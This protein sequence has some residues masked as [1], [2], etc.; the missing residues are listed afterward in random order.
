MLDIRKEYLDEL[1][2]IF[3]GYCP[4]A[5]IWA[6]GS[7]I[8]NNSHSGSD[9]DLAVKNLNDEKKS[10]TELRRI[11]NDSD[12]PFLIEIQE[13]AKLPKSFQDEIMKDYIQIFPIQENINGEDGL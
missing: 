9:L 5:E 3:C 11:L 1:R 13:F 10:V 4:K 6:Y 8:K 2:S 7:R 12:I